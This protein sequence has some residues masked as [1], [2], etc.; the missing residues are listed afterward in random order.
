M[1]RTTS[2]I[3]AVLACIGIVIIYAVI[4]ALLGWKHGGGVL[5]MTILF[6]AITATWKGIIGLSKRKNPEE[7][8]ED[9]EN[10]N[11]NAT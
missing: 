2:Y 9:I 7:K 6:G 10:E 3:V 11:N 8:V 1:N 5:P 4:G